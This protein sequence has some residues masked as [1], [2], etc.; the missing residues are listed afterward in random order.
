MVKRTLA[1]PLQ[2]AKA[3]PKTH[4]PSPK[5]TAKSTTLTGASPRYHLKPQRIPASITTT[6]PK[7]QNNAGTSEGFQMVKRTLARPL[8]KANAQPMP[9]PTAQNQQLNPQP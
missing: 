9:Q 1:R 3:Q 4:P 7:A 5:P 6:T 2:K 8:Q